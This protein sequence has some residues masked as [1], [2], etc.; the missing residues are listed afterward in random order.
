MLEC[1]GYIKQANIE[2]W[3]NQRWF[4]G[5]IYEEL[6]GVFSSKRDALGAVHRGLLCLHRNLCLMCYCVYLAKILIQ[7]FVCEMWQI[8][9]HASMS[10]FAAV[11]YSSTLQIFI[12]DI[13]VCI[14]ALHTTG[15]SFHTFFLGFVWNTAMYLCVNELWVVGF[16]FCLVI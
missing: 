6:L 8:F 12:C 1:S 3:E 10:C 13:I 4:I 14:L 11:I 16:F 9:E 2:R 5:H 7:L 15:N